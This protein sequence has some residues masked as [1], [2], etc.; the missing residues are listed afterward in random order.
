V[1]SGDRLGPTSMTGVMDLMVRYRVIPAPVDL[2]SMI[3]QQGP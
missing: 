2:G 3:T 1:F